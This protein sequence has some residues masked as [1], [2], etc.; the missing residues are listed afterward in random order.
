MR[1]RMRQALT[2]LDKSLF[3]PVVVYMLL[4]VVAYAETESGLVGL[5]FIAGML[6]KLQAGQRTID[7]LENAIKAQKGWT[8][9][10]RRL[11][12]ALQDVAILK[13]QNRT[14]MKT[15]KP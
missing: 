8:E 9:T 15:R 14:L 13:A 7:A 11:I 6:L 10:Q 4:G 2:W 1:E 5:L 3:A 12:A